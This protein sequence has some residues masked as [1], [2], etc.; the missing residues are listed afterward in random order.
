MGRHRQTT[1]SQGNTME[2]YTTPTPLPQHQTRMGGSAEALVVPATA[3][4]PLYAEILAAIQGTRV[5][6][7][8]KI[9]MVAVE[10]NILRKDLCKV[11]D[12]VKVAEGSIMDLQTEVG[13][14]RKQMTQ[15]TSTV[16]VWEA[17]LEDSEG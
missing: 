9:E 6:L 3:E 13:T 1:P 12:M 14:L 10:V 4:E 2:Q 7:G 11:S 17:K 16:G 15:V 5:A 8:G